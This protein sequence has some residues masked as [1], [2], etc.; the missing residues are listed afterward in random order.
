MEIDLKVILSIIGSFFAAY[1]WLYNNT[2]TNLQQSLYR[3]EKISL[4][5]AHT[6]EQKYK[7]SL[8]SLISWLDNIYNNA[9]FIQNYSR[10]ITIALLYSFMVFLLFWVLGAEGKIGT[11]EVLKNISTEK[12][13][14]SFILLTLYI[15]FI[16]IIY[17]KATALM[18]YI[19]KRVPKNLQE[20]NIVK[21]FIIMLGMG[22]VMGLGGMIRLGGGVG[23]IIG[24]VG[25]MAAV[26]RLVGSSK[27]SPTKHGLGII[28]ILIGLLLLITISE[29]NSK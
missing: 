29:S 15:L 21:N 24:F 28:L 14:T 17:N 18:N 16:Y 23:G 11:I 3:K 27:S 6:F 2:K 4:L 10:H 7:T 5:E 25:G 12:R 19:T 20:S 9:T 8:Q 26:G 13:V 1:F 22:V